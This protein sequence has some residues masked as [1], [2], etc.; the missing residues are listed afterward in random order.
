MGHRG[1]RVHLNSMIGLEKVYLRVLGNF[2]SRKLRY[3]LGKEKKS[4]NH[5]GLTHQHS[6]YDSSRKKTLCTRSNGWKSSNESLIFVPLFHCVVFRQS[7]GMHS[8]ARSL[9]KM[10]LKCFGCMEGGKK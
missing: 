2:F 7:P 6:I 3:I 8:C 10:C 9:M 1:A 4:G 5:P